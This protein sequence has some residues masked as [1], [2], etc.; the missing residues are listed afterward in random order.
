MSPSVVASGA[1]P[2]IMLGDLPRSFR[3]PFFRQKKMR[4]TRSFPLTYHHCQG[5]MCRKVR[6]V[7]PRRGCGARQQLCRT[8]STL[9]SQLLI[10]NCAPAMSALASLMLPRTDRTSGPGSS[11]PNRAVPLEMQTHQECPPRRVTPLEC[12]DTKNGLISPLECTDTNSLDLKSFRFRS[13]KKHRGGPLPL[14]P[15]SIS[16]FSIPSP[17]C[18]LPFTFCLL[19]FPSCLP[20]SLSQPRRRSFTRCRKRIG[21]PGKSNLSRSW[22][23]RKRS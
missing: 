12:T 21:V 23:S 13:Y 15:F 16:P 1:S 8:R 5:N 10:A 3:M 18:L 9:N 17:L 2:P 7:R 4:K 6:S 11:A 14:Q 20:V 19:R 22:F